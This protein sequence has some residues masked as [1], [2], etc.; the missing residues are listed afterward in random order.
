MCVL[1]IE[2]MSKFALFLPLLLAV[3][4]GGKSPPPESPKPAADEAQDSSPKA[5][6]SDGESAAATEDK[7]NESSPAEQKKP[8]DKSTDGPK[9]TRSAQD[10][11]TAPDVVFMLSF[12]DSDVKKTADSKCTASSGNDPK[13]LNACMAKAR[14]AMDVDGYRFKEKDGKWYWSTLRTQGKIVHTTHKFEVEFGPEKEGSIT[15]KPKGKDLGSSPGRTPSSV[16]ISV[17]N[18]YQ[19]V[20]NDPKLGKL[21]Y[22]AKIGIAS[23]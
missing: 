19:M 16:T 11:L 9:P 12:N 14:Q 20:L 8:A 22:E 15:L 1:T 21:V 17:P 5:A 23:E 4:C 7:K 13:K 3:A 18:D 6:G 2:H 10:I